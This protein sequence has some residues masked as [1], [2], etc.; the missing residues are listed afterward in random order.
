VIARAILPGPYT[1]VFRNPARRY[2]WLTGLNPD[3]IGI[4]IPEFE[5]PGREVLDRASALMATSAN[6]HGAREPKTLAE[7]AEVI[8]A[9][10]GAV[11]DGGE[12]PGVPS[13]VIDFTGAEPRVLREGAASG[14]EAIERALA[15]VV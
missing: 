6:I 9:G 5:G 4:R 10:S 7:V 12:V 11:V 15:A 2:R 8:R 13:T 1:L 14:A 3:A